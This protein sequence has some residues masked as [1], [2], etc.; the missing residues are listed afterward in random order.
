MTATRS[1]LIRV[2]AAAAVLAL[3]LTGCA[4][5]RGAAAI[6]DGDVIS[7][8]YL[9]DTVADIAP[10]S[11]AGP[12]SVLQALVVG[13]IWIDV[14][15]EA[16]FG[17]SEQEARDLLEQLA[18]DTGVDATDLDPG[19]GLLTIAQVT[20]VQDK[21][22]SGGEAPYLNMKVQQRVAAADIAVSP[23]YGEWLT[24]ESRGIDPIAWPWLTTSAVPA[25]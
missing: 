14:A 20:A 13:P 22:N 23:R 15:S 8:A 11:G 9:A 12:T 1:R 5:Q 25:G 6:V 4:G 21:A 24:D 16:G 7:E 18:A 3:G 10:F 17:A 19:P 2:A